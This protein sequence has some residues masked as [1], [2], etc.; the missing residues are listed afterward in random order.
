MRAF[1]FDA[2]GFSPQGFRRRRQGGDARQG[3]KTGRCNIVWAGKIERGAGLLV[4]PKSRHQGV[5]LIAVQRVDQGVEAA[6]LD[7]A[8]NFQFLADGARQIDIEFREGF[9]PAVRN[10]MADN[11][12]RSGSADCAHR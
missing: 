4:D 2:D 1:C 5:A 7:R 9:R 8:G 10:G 3:Y 6:C 11:R 12:R